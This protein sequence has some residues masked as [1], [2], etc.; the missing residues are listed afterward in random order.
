VAQQ[1]RVVLKGKYESGDVPQGSDYVDLIDSFPTLA[2]TTTQSITSDLS[3]PGLIVTNLSAASAN[4]TGGLRIEG[5]ITV[6]GGTNFLSQSQGFLFTE[7]TGLASASATF[8]EV[9]ISASTLAALTSGFATTAASLQYTGSQ[10]KRFIADIKMSFAASAAITGTWLTVGVNNSAQTRYQQRI[11]TSGL[12]ST[13]L[14]ASGIVQLATN[15][16]LHAMIRGS[17]ADGDGFQIKNLTL[18]VKE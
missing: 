16:R 11:S 8:V 17:A 3:V 7:V 2:D 12:S 5:V 9:N 18:T 10:T 6:S 14:A 13:F 15:D 4:V 1:T